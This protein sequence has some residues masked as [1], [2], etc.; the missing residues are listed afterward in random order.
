MHRTS[1][2]KPGLFNGEVSYFEVVS[3]D[4]KYSSNLR[5]VEVT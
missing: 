2:G 5:Y 1:G 3:N 4:F